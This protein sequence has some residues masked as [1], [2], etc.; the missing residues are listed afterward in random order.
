MSSDAEFQNLIDTLL[1][2][3]NSVERMQ[4]AKALGDYVD[5][6]SDEEYEDAKTALN[7]AMAD[8]DPMVLTTAMS[9]MTKFN[10][11]GIQITG[12]IEFE[13]DDRDDLIHPPEKAVCDVCHRPE[14]LIPEDG[15]EREDCPYR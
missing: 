7:R 9:A 12:D 15:C 1:T 2:G 3:S 6:L 13:G 10:R 4:A 5:D 14:A 8:P 11:S